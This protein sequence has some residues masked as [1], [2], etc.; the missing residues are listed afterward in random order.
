MCSLRKITGAGETRVHLLWKS[1]RKWRIYIGRNHKII[2]VKGQPERGEERV[3]ED[4]HT[5]YF[6][7]GKCYVI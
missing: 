6:L 2:R 7:P 4:I 1:G 5:F 3:E